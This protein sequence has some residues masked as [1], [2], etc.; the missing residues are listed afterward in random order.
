VD[1]ILDGPVQLGR[2]TIKGE[3]GNRLAVWRRVGKW[4]SNLLCSDGTLLTKG[5]GRYGHIRLAGHLKSPLK[6]A[7]RDC[8]SDGP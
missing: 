6:V 3:P 4:R 2:R 8:I 1:Q 5:P 7:A